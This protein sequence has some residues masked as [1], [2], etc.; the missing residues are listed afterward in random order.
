[1]FALLEDRKFK[2]APLG[3][4][5]EM[6]PR[7]DHIKDPAYDRKSVDTPGLSL[8][9]KRQLDFL[10]HWATDWTDAQM[11]VALSQTAFCGAVHL[12]GSKNNRLLADLD[13]NGWPQ[14][15]RN[16]A[17]RILRKAR[18]SHLCG[19]Q[20]LA[21]VVK[22]GID[23]FRDGPMTFTNPALVNTIYG[24]WW[25]PE[26]EK[27]GSGAKIDSPLPWTGDYEDGFGNK[28]TM[29]A[30]ANPEHAHGG[31]LRKNRPNRGDGFGIARFNKATGQISFECY[32]RFWGEKTAAEVQYKGW[33]ISFHVS[34]NDGRKPIAH[35]PEI[36]LTE[37]DMVVGLINDVSG[38]TV[39]C[40][41][42]RGK[43][44]TAPVYAKGSYTLKAGK[45]TAD[46]VIAK[47]KF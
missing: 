23:S 2:S 1:S 9:G 37:A 24:R 4:I 13:S 16:K 31:E 8:L 42:V 40:H 11:K 32:P 26:D 21:V 3:N 27:P 47:Q 19:D 5:P 6:G 34:D 25:W 33:P 43:S 10:E 14:T 7:P 38:E 35:F 39:Y 28:I 18:A 46:T 41:R 29:L 15:G 44:F 12:H 20:H 45:S 30:Y 36:N 17:L 22:Q